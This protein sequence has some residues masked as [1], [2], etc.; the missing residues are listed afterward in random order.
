MPRFT[1]PR[2][3]SALAIA[4]CVSLSIPVLL[5]QR[6]YVVD[7]T[8]HLWLI[9]QQAHALTANG[10]PTFFLSSDRTGLLYPFFAFYGGTLYALAGALAVALGSSQ[11]S[12]LVWWIAGFAM[13]YGGT[14]WI[15]RLA[16]LGRAAAHAPAL[17]IVTSA[18]FLTNL[19]GRGAFSEFV[20][21]AAIPLATAGAVALVTQE[22]PPVATGV[23]LVFATVIVTGSHNITLLWG[24]VVAALLV[25]ALVPALG[26]WAW[27]RRPRIALVLVLVAL[28]TMVN[29]WF[30]V[31]D[32]I[33]ADRVNASPEGAAFYGDVT[34][35]DWGTILVPWR[36]IP[37]TSRTSTTST[38]R[39][40]CWPPP[41]AWP[42]VWPISAGSRRLCG[43]HS[44]ACA[45]CSS[46]S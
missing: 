46:S 23:A 29:G 41:G 24:A 30:L 18:Y 35:H 22:Q 43:V 45:P 32:I 44:W 19:Y 38:S 36:S 6:A 2:V 27:A 3:F 31:P 40:P 15:G 26:S 37:P 12:Y 33:Y 20:A 11:A 34:L 8:N 42:Q 16:G 28:A 17:V 10:H 1:A 25:A 14:W 5:T 9:D 39:C 13:A 7:W 4:V 21:T